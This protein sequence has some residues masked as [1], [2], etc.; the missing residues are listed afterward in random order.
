MSLSGQ[1]NVSSLTGGSG[2]LDPSE[3]LELRG[4]DDESIELND[5]SGTPANRVTSNELIF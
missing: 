3:V 2:L 4:S 1:K 5:S